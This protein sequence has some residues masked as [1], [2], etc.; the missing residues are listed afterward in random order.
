MVFGAEL[1]DGYGMAVAKHICDICIICIFPLNCQC[2][3]H[4]QFFCFN[5]DQYELG[6][7][8]RKL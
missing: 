5:L 4:E 8:W 2:L 1:N 7:N 6:A 3:Q